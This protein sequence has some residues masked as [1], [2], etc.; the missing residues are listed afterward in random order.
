MAWRHE[1]ELN[2]A[3]IQMRN[4]GQLAVLG[5]GG[6]IGLQDWLAQEFERAGFDKAKMAR[7]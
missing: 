6:Y 3:A 4:S 5:L 1:N 2:A 7:L